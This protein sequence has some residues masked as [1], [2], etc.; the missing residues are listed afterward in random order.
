VVTA[1]HFW[2]DAAVGLTVLGAGYLAGSRIAEFWQ[3]RATSSVAV[4]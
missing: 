4:V 2:L 3:R 1:N